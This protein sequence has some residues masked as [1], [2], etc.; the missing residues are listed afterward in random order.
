[1]RIR[2]I[3]LGTEDILYIHVDGEVELRIAIGEDM[4]TILVDM[5]VKNFSTLYNPQAGREIDRL[6]S[7]KK[8]E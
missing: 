7:K 8:E 3:R 4:E 2:R 6:A 5:K 1:M